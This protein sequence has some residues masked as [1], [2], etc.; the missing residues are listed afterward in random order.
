MIIAKG[1]SNPF[2]FYNNMNFFNVNCSNGI[3]KA[4]SKKDFLH[5]VLIAKNI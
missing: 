3:I 4:M 5:D 2:C 1:I